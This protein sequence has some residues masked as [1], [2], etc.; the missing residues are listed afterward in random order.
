M[1]PDERRVPGIGD[2]DDMELHAFERMA[3]AIDPMLMPE[4]PD[5]G[6]NGL[7]PMPETIF[8]AQTPPGMS[9]VPFQQWGETYDAE[10]GF[11]KGTM[12]PVMDLP[13]APEKGGCAE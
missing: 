11:S 9:Y 7:L 3:Q 13:F 12:F 8:P 4:N 6:E 1:K 5:A 10:T 2:D